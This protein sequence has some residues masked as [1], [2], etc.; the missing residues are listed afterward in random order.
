ATFT[1]D[2]ARRLK[3]VS[4]PLT[5][6]TA[7]YGYAPTGE[8]ASIGFGTGAPSRAYTLDNLG[9]LATDTLVKAD[10][11]PAASTTYGYDLDDLVPSRATTGLAGAGGNGYGYD[12][13][14]RL[15]AWTRPDNQQIGYGYDAA[16][17][18]TTVT[19]PA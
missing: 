5:G 15:T 9:R 1:Y 17:N 6:R 13:L 11:K 8:L 10:G 18:R 14:G 19:G 4:D 2:D 12:G 3:T 16:S 7:T